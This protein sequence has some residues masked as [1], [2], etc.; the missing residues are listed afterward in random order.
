MCA[1]VLGTL[2]FCPALSFMGPDA[3]TRLDS[4]Q[5]ELERISLLT[6]L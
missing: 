2:L 6:T 5:E 3:E 4:L 1:K